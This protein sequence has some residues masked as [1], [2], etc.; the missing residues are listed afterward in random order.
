LREGGEVVGGGGLPGGVV[1]TLV[2]L[3][4]NVI[5]DQCVE[6]VVRWVRGPEDVVFT[7]VWVTIDPFP[8]SGVKNCP[9]TGFVG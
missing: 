9:F 3:V 1:D 5:P 7:S 8:G 4:D 6:V 2:I